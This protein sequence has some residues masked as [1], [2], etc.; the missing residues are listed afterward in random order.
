MFRVLATAA[1]LAVVVASLLIGATSA[2]AHTTRTVGPYELKVGWV[3]EPA[4]AGILNSLELGVTD[5]RTNAPVSGLEKTLRVQL[6]AG[7]L[8]PVTLAI[9]PAED[10]AGAYRAWV[11]PTVTGSYTF[12]VTGKIEAQNVDEKFASGPD[13][14]ADVTSAAGAQYP[15]KVPQAS[16]LAA[17]LADL[18]A[19]ADQAR[20]IAIAAVA[21]GIV[22]LAAA[23]VTRRRA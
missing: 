4:Y 23:L 20:L 6:A 18:R 9:E 11:I 22:A 21:I 1:S 17:Q 8:A 14:F 10:E 12:H 19:S 7:G 13:T 2:V 3:S 16:D 5:T 15:V